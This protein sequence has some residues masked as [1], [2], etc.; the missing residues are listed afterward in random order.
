MLTLD[1]EVDRVT[2]D[3]ISF[4]ADLSTI[5]QSSVSA[6]VLQCVRRQLFLQSN[7]PQKL[8]GQIL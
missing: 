3:K 1:Y 5:C 4:L 7:S 8:K 6:S 2:H